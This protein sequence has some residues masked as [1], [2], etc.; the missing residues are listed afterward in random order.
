MTAAMNEKILSQPRR[1]TSPCNVEDHGPSK[2]YAEPTTQ[3]NPHVDTPTHSAATQRTLIS[4][5]SPQRWKSC[6]L[7]RR[8]NPRQ[9][10]AR[11]RETCRVEVIKGCMRYREAWA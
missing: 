5:L 2:Q 8:V 9:V 11:T 1:P 3:L 4:A 7:V 6:P 10:A